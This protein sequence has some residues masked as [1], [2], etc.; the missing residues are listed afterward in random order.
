M[1]L[2]I[3]Q[4]S[5]NDITE[6]VQMICPSNAYSPVVYNPRK[7][8]VILVKQDE[9][10]EPIH[11]YE[12]R[13]SIVV[14]KT[15]SSAGSKGISLFLVDADLPGF[16]KGKNLKKL[17]LKAQDTSELFFQDVRVPKE[18]LLGEEGRGFIYLMQDLPQER[19]SI[20]IGA[21]A[22]AQAVLE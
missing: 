9:Y 11:L 8:T 17:G 3:L 1:N 12:Q 19:L 7:E 21:V 6:R 16:S 14:A 20:A 18:N 4:I 2:V 15:D 10:F 13:D 22:N 5:D